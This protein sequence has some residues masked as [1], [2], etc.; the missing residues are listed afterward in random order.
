MNIEQGSML[1][2]DNKICFWW[3]Y[4]LIVAKLGHR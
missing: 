4:I 2:L 1:Y 3:K